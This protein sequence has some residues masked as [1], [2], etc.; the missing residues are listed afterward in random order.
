[1][2]TITRALKFMPAFSTLAALA[3]RGAIF[4]ELTVRKQPGGKGPRDKWG[5][6]R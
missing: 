4:V 5:K 2:T 1:M 3:L 6:L